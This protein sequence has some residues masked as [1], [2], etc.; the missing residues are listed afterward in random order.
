MKVW[1][2]K[3]LAERIDGVDLSGHNVGDVLDL[4]SRDARLLMA[5]D[6]AKP[7]RRV[8]NR[9]TTQKRRSADYAFDQHDDGMQDLSETG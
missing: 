9:Q 4:P 5:E 8:R 2:T 6:W 3:K 7:D 1:L